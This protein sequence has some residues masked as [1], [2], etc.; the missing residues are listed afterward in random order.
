MV[1]RSASSAFMPATKSLIAGTWASTL[2]PMI[3]SARGPLAARA[4]PSSSPK[5]ARRTGMPSC[6]GC[7]R[8]ARCGFDSEAGNPGRDE[9]AQQVAVVAGDLDHE[10]LRPKLQACRHRGDVVPRVPQEGRGDRREVG[11]VRREQ[12]VGAGIVLR[13]DQPTSLAYQQPQRVAPLRAAKIG[14]A[15]IGIGRRREAEVEEAAPQRLAAMAAVHGRSAVG[16]PTV[17]DALSRADSSVTGGGQATATRR[18]PRSGEV[19]A[20][21]ATRLAD[22]PELTVVA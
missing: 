19:S 6:L 3:R 22:D 12:L 11:V 2:L 15:E 5:N 18:S 1:P 20:E 21:N 7:R 4:R 10:A 9:I 8:R 16:D 14:L 17:C 13:L